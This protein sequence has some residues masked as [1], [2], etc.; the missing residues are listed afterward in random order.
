MISSNSR[1]TFGIILVANL[2]LASALA[3]A[4]HRFYVTKARTFNPS[5]GGMYP[6]PQRY[7]VVQKITHAHSPI[8]YL[9]DWVIDDHLFLFHWAGETTTT[10]LDRVMRDRS[11]DGK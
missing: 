5:S 10:D 3:E 7:G 9:D 1:R 8:L 4:C 6:L 11:V 2:L